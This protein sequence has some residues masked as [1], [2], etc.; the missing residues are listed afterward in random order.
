M[1]L[2]DRAICCI[3]LSFLF[4]LF[5][6]PQWLLGFRVEDDLGG[7]LEHLSVLYFESDFKLGGTDVVLKNGYDQLLQCLLDAPPPPPPPPSPESSSVSMSPQS[8]S[9]PFSLSAVSA[10]LHMSVSDIPRVAA[11]AA[12]ISAPSSSASVSPFDI[13]LRLNQIVSRISYGGNR[14]GNGGA[15]GDVAAP[16]SVFTS[17]FRVA[18][19][20]DDLHIILA[21][22][23]LI[24]FFFSSPPLLLLRP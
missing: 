21:A 24:S 6:I 10:T 20:R 13:D 11:A 23:L 22:S 14:D 9:S 4:L 1:R 8:A 15:K 18:R 17:A 12:G 16:V 2:L 19:D 3:S 7:S 5:M